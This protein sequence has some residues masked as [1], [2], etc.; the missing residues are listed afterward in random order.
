MTR[1]SYIKHL[2]AVFAS[3]PFREK[4]GCA[5]VWIGS[6]LFYNCDAVAVKALSSLAAVCGGFIVAIVPKNAVYR[7]IL[8]SV[9]VG[10]AIVGFI[11][12]FIRNAL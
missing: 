9:A 12:I 11:I 3:V 6:I 1:F 7:P 4:L 8:T 2:Q 10:G 5:M